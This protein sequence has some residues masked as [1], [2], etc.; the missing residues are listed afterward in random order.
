VTRDR[1]AVLAIWEQVF[2]HG[3]FT[4]RSSCFF[5][6]EGIGSIYWHMVA[7]LLV[8][9]QENVTGA[10]KAGAPAETVAALS[11]AYRAIRDGLGYRKP[12]DVYGAVPTDPY[13]HSPRHTGAQQP[14]M[15]GQVKE[16]ILTRWGE[17]GI[18]IEDGCLRFAPQL[19]DASEFRDQ[20]STFAYVDALGAPQ[21]IA[22]PAASLAFTCCGTP[23]CYATGPEPGIVVRLCDGTTRRLGG[24]LDLPPE[25][26]AAVFG[27][28]GEVL[29][30]DVSRTPGG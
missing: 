1:E 25:E 29:R 26:S 6:F 17:L 12:P 10:R 21:S 16:E 14:G 28:T 22:L 23:V 2:R 19:A 3:E 9:V 15:T 5:M 20:P 27:R 11:D 24:S 7:K 13:S 18:L 8:A 4:G 30:I